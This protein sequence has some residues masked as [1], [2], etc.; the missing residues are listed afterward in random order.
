MFTYRPQSPLAM[1]FCFIVALFTFTACGSDKQSETAIAPAQIVTVKDTK[2]ADT[3]FLSDATDIYF[4]EILLAKLAQQRATA[5]EVKELSKGIEETSRAGKAQITAMTINKSITVPTAPSAMANA[6]YDTLGKIA[7]EE[8]DVIYIRDVILRHNTALS[9]FENAAR[10]E[11]DA[12]IQT[13][14]STK[15]TELRNQL[16]KA[17]EIDARL[18]PVSELVQ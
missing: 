11:H 12:D 3:R 6:A 14:A 18:N 8:F 16:L 1:L 13:W 17:K 9:H 10:E 2:V 15:I 7:L 4:Q 5:H